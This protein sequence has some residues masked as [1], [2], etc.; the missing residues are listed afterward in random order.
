MAQRNYPCDS[1]IDAYFD[2]SGTYFTDVGELPFKRGLYHCMLGQAIEMKSNIETRKSTN[3]I[4]HILWQLNEIW[5]TGGWGSLEYGTPNF[6]GQVIGGRWKPLHYMLGREIFTDISATCGTLSCYVRNDLPGLSFNGT[7][8]IISI[9][10]GNGVTS[11]IMKKNLNI[12]SGPSQLSWF[13]LPTNFQ[14]VS[15]SVVFQLVVT[16]QNQH[17]VATN[18]LL[19][20]VPKHLKG[21]PSDSGL[22]VMVVDDDDNDNDNDVSGESG[23]A[24]T[25][26]KVSSNVPVSLYVTL[27]TLAQ[28]RFEDNA[29]A[30]VCDSSHFNTTT[31][32]Q[33]ECSR[34]LKFFHFVDVDQIKLLKSSLRVE[35]LAT[36]Q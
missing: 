3:Q 28:G 12:V 35:D 23:D 8:K 17:V 9:N 30:L 4:G 25:T 15:S 10:I 6:P 19:R 21:L 31:S 27:T 34:T 22:T 18:T 29:F 24:T 2:T 7:L 1:I 20:D 33:G 11:T 26:I 36:Y 14:G 5:P 16:D 13:D 32:T